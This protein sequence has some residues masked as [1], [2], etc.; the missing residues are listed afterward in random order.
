ML[1]SATIEENYSPVSAARMRDLRNRLSRYELSRVFSVS[2]GLTRVRER[3][4]K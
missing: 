3:Q 2:D 4:V 1:F